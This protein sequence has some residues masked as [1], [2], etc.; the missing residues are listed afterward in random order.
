MLNEKHGRKPL[1]SSRNPFTCGITGKTYTASEQVQRVEHLARALSK[2][3]G[4]QPNTGA[5][6]DKVM[7]IFSLNTVGRSVH[8]YKQ[9]QGTNNNLRLIS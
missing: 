8:M 5:E 7:G 4:W 3:L 6:W 2:E 1:K 9:N